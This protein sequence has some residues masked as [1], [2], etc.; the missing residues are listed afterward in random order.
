MSLESAR[1]FFHYVQDDTELERRLSQCQNAEEK[2]SLAASQGFDFTVEEARQ[3]REELSDEDLEA[4]AGG[5]ALETVQCLLC[6]RDFG[7]YC[8]LPSA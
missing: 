5:G 4:L 6:S 3:I 8:D 2:I 7:K 1:S